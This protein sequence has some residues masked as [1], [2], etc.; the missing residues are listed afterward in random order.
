[1]LKLVVFWVDMEWSFE[2]KF[3]WSNEYLDLSSEIDM[4]LFLVCEIK[5]SA[6][7]EWNTWVV[8]H[9][10]RRLALMLGWQLVCRGVCWQW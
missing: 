2:Q 6:K 3:F 8:Q 10:C 5:T 9:Q 4:G 1:V 7:V